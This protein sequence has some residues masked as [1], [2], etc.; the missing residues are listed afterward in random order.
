MDKI[1][2]GSETV[3]DFMNVETFSQLPFIRPTTTTPFKEKS[4]VT[5]TSAGAIRLFGKEFGSGSPTAS[6]SADTDT[7]CDYTKPNTNNNSSSNK[8]NNSSNTNNNNSEN[9]DSNRRFE[10]HYCCRN[11]P[12]SQALGGHQ[13]AHKR[14]RQHAKRAQ[15][16][17]LSTNPQV[18][19]LMNNNYTLKY[20]YPSWNSN[21]VT[22]NYT[23]SSSIR[24]YGRNQYGSSY[25]HAPLATTSEPINGNPLGLWRI[26]TTVQNIPTFNLD[27]SM[28]QHNNK[29]LLAG[30]E[31]TKAS[32]VGGSSQ[33]TSVPEH[34]SL[35]LHL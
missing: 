15:Y 34:V 14:E 21:S 19:E 16:N 1:A 5:G 31:E 7:P 2:E 30:F 23:N 12:T 33:S 3:H 26:P 29:P 27:R 28:N 35:D 25:S 13:N 10:C 11:F 18:Y 6:E 17:S 22:N 8:N 32:Q 9:G 4:V 24:F 20:N